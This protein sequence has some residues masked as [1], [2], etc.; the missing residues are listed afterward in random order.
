MYIFTNLSQINNHTFY[1][2][3]NEKESP[4]L[5]ILLSLNSFFSLSYASLILTHILIFIVRAMLVQFSPKL[6]TLPNPLLKKKC[7][8]FLCRY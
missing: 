2:E 3:N 6:T 8:S 7:I 4:H 1:K 5:L